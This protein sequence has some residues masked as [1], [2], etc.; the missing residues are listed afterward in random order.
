MFTFKDEVQE[1]KYCSNK[2]H[3]TVSLY[4]GQFKDHETEALELL[5]HM[6]NIVSRLFDLD[7]CRT[8]VAP[9][10]EPEGRRF[11]TS[12]SWFCVLKWS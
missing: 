10:A 8:A 5:G 3:K 6:K 2:L 4:T 11:E 7:V 12:P 9:E 1:E